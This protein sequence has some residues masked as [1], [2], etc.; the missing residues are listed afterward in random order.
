MTNADPKLILWFERRYRLEEQRREVAEDIKELRKEGVST[1]LLK[2]EVAG[3]E[4][5]VKRR[6]MS[7]K[8]RAAKTAAE[9]VADQLALTGSPLFEAAAA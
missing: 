9:E 4:L 1:G 2:E 8:K 5:E 6:F 3:A 7:D